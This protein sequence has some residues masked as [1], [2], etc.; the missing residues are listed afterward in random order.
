M[1][2]YRVLV[3]EGSEEWLRAT[4]SSTQAAIK[5]TD[6]EMDVCELL[7]AD[8]TPF[9]VP[10]GTITEIY[11]SESNKELTEEVNDWC[12][13]NHPMRRPPK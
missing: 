2:I 12:W 7:T 4:L 1:R 5:P 3:M 11:R 10:N 9:T 13:E 8:M 6:P